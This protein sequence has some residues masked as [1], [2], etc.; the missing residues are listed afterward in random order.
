MV[1]L[2]NSHT[3]ATKIGW[4]LWEIDFRFAPGAQKLLPPRQNAPCPYGIAYRRVPY[5]IA[6][7]RVLGTLH[8]MAQEQVP[9]HN[10]FKS[11]LSMGAS[12]G[13][14]PEN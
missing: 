13:A 12:V 2:V 1:S 9:L 8:L 7:R 6:Y 14:A 5:G 4:H 3:D 11:V 10:A